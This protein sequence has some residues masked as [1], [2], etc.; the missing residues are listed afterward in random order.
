M[1]IPD[2]EEEVGPE[3][4]EFVAKMANKC[5]RV[6]KKSLPD[7]AN[8]PGNCANLVQ[9]RV[10][11]EVWS[12]LPTSA[13]KGDIRLQRVHD[14]LVASMI[15]NVNAADRLLEDALGG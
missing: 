5:M 6:E 3:V 12:G 10:N 14:A 11:T 8:R 15:Y 9:T 13:Q 1:D 7:R 4:S 2:Q